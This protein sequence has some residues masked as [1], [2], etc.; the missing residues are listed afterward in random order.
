MMTKL[1][2]YQ[3]EVRLLICVVYLQRSTH[4]DLVVLTLG[5]EKA[6]DQIEWEYLFE[7]LGRFNLGT[8]FI[9]WIKLLYTNPTAR[10]RTNQS[11]SS[12]FR[13]FRGTQQGCPLSALIFALAI[14]PLAQNIRLDPQIHGYQIKSTLSKISLYADDIP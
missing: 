3:V 1:V 5:A 10:V 2:S 14:E 13:L 4:D 6:F 12:S 11:L 7:V 8:R 9:N